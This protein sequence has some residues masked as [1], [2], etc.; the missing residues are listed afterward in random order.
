MTKKKVV[1]NF[2][3]LL[4]IFCAGQKNLRSSPGR[5][6]TPLAKSEDVWAF[7]AVHKRRPQIGGGVGQ[8]RIAR[9]G[10]AG[11]FISGFDIS[12][13]QAHWVGSKPIRRVMQLK[14]H[15]P[16]MAIGYSLRMCARYVDSTNTGRRNL[17]FR[18]QPIPEA[19]MSNRLII[20][21]GLA[22]TMGVNCYPSCTIFAAAGTKI[23]IR[24][25]LRSK[26][27]YIAHLLGCRSWPRCECLS[28][29]GRRFNFH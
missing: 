24:L 12:C 25:V 3:E 14:L 28:G 2:G 13:A 7:V 19:E 1:R 11:T 10:K 22:D 9:R 6:G 5:L 26:V 18:S 15:K 29:G 21:T 16:T 8:V 4:D 20:T 23:Y 27:V 17:V